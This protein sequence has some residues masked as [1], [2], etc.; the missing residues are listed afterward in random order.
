MLFR[1]P[2]KKVDIQPTQLAKPDVVVKDTI[3]PIVRTPIVKPKPEVVKPEVAK[4]KST[5][6]ANSIKSLVDRLNKV[7]IPTPPKVDPI[8]PE[9]SKIK[10]SVS[11]E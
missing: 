9:P 5:T 8:P 10:L 11:K 4:P 7:S 1:S 3:K 2:G 6:D